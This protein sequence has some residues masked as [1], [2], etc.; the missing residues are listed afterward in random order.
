MQLQTCKR[1]ESDIVWSSVVISLPAHTHLP[2]IREYS[3]DERKAHESTTLPLGEHHPAR[4]RHDALT[5]SES[6]HFREAK[7]AYRKPQHRPNRPRLTDTKNAHDEGCL[8][9]RLNR[10]TTESSMG[11][12]GIQSWDARPD[13]SRHQLVWERG[14]A[15]GVMKLWG[16]FGSCYWSQQHFAVSISP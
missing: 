15:S 16:A 2:T 14:R 3:C 7:S 8:G 13:H 1:F 4:N 12:P 6:H 10:A 5:S 11:S 9:R